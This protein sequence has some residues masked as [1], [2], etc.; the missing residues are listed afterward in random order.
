VT[1]AG[2]TPAP[3]ASVAFTQPATTATAR[4]QPTVEAVVFRA[5]ERHS[6]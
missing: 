5:V 1:A 2:T 4:T 6:F 3:T